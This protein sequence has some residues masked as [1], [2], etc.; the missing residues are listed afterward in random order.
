[1]N[2]FTNQ[3]AWISGLAAVAVV[4]GGATIQADTIIGE[5]SS[6]VLAGEVANDPAIGDLTFLNNTL[7]AVDSIS[8]TVSTNDTM[9][10]GTNPGQSTLAFFGTGNPIPADP[11]TPFQIGSLFFFNGTSDLT[12]LI[13]GA[14]LSF[15]QQSS[16]DPS[17]LTPLGSDNVIITTTSNQ[18]SGTGL[19]T[20]QLQTDADYVNVCGFSAICGQSL[21][22]Y[23]STENAV[24]GFIVVDL[25]G[26][27]FGDPQLTVTSAALES[28]SIGNGVIGTELAQ[29][30]VPEPATL[31]L[32]S[33]G[34]AL[35]GL[36]RRRA[37]R[38]SS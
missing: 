6:P 17:I 18:Y 28:S 27:I 34:L 10:W 31:V 24:G 22:A 35:A 4:L 2:R 29:G 36:V 5:F 1:M 11:T 16:S 19:T 20:A 8:T 23:E 37:L 12:T 14:T 7:T 33:T 32:M 9:R 13:F 15:Y 3:C 30:E 25:Y 26:T 21:E 38:R